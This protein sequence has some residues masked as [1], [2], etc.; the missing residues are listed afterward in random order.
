MGMISVY[1]HCFCYSDVLT[2]GTKD[3]FVSTAIYAL[4][5]T[6]MT[7]GDVNDIFSIP[8]AFFRSLVL[9]S[10]FITIITFIII[11]TFS[12]SCKSSVWILKPKPDSHYRA[13]Q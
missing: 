12:V 4:V 7:I 8:S 6:L 10:V 3:P 13:L 9:G 11:K 1:K 2:T 5:G